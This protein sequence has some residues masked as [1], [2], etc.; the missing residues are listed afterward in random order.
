MLSARHSNAEIVLRLT[1]IN[2][3]ISLPASLVTAACLRVI[4]LFYP[5]RGDTVCL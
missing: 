2:S 3:L 4:F 1:V 5:P